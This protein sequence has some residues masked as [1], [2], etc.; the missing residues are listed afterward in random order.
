MVS[1]V[2]AILCLVIVAGVYYASDTTPKQLSRQDY[3]KD[4]IRAVQL[5]RKLLKYRT[6]GADNN[7]LQD[8]YEEIVR[9][10]VEPSK[11]PKKSDYVTS[12]EWAANLELLFNQTPY[13]PRDLGMPTE[14]KA[15]G[16]STQVT[17]A[18][19]PEQQNGDN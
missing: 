3:A 19:P 12:A 10:G 11:I 18:R 1:V 14:D 17:W 8:M 7:I 6:Q 16:K 2:D 9:R 4:K 15:V 13:V 5:K